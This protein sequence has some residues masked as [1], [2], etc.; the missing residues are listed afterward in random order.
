VRLRAR[1]DDNHNDIADLFTSAGC[2]VVDTSQLGKGFPDMVIGLCGINVLVE[3]KD[4]D[5]SPSK[6]K[7][8]EDEF[9]FFHNWRGWVAVVRDDKDALNIISQIKQQKAQ[10]MCGFAEM[11]G[12]PK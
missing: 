8:T 2:T 7:L 4:G 10:E 1:K 3:V 12:L 11:Q 9:K 5:K 6:Q